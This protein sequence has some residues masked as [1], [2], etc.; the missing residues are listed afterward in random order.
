MNHDGQEGVPVV[1]SPAILFSLDVR[2]PLWLSAETLRIT[3]RVPEQ[4]DLRRVW[5]FRMRKELRIGL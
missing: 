1:A 3:N 5:R 2:F 4:S